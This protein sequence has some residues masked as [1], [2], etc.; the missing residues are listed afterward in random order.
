MGFGQKE[1]VWIFPP[2][3]HTP[4]LVPA[5]KIPAMRPLPDVVAGNGTRAKLNDAFLRPVPVFDV[6]SS[7]RK[8][9]AVSAD[10][11]FPV[12]AVHARGMT[13]SATAHYSDP[14]V[15]ALL[16]EL[17]SITGFAD[18]TPPAFDYAGEF[19]CSSIE[20]AVHF[21]LVAWLSSS[22]FTANKRKKWK[23]ALLGTTSLEKASS[24][25]WRVTSPDFKNDSRRKTFSWSAPTKKEQEKLDAGNADQF[26]KEFFDDEAAAFQA[27]QQFNYQIRPGLSP[28]RASLNLTTI[29]QD[30]IALHNERLDRKARKESLNVSAPSVIAED[31]LPSFQ[32]IIRDGRFGICLDS[33]GKKTRYVLGPPLEYTQLSQINECRYEHESYS[34]SNPHILAD[35]LDASRAKPI[36]AGTQPLEHETLTPRELVELPVGETEQ[37]A[38]F[39]PQEVNLD[40]PVTGRDDLAN[41]PWGFGMGCGDAKKDGASIYINHEVEILKRIDK[42]LV[43]KLGGV[44][45]W[46]GGIAYSVYE[47]LGPG[48]SSD[49]P[50]DHFLTKENLRYIQDKNEWELRLMNG[51]CLRFGGIDDGKHGYAE[52]RDV[53]DQILRVEAEAEARSAAFAA[54]VAQAAQAAQAEDGEEEEGEEA[55]EGEKDVDAE[56]SKRG[57]NLYARAWKKEVPWNGKPGY[58]NEPKHIPLQYATLPIPIRRE[59]PEGFFDS[60]GHCPPLRPHKLTYIQ[61]IPS[62]ERLLDNL[63][64]ILQSCGHNTSRVLRPAQTYCIEDKNGTVR[65]GECGEAIYLHA[66]HNT[67]LIHPA[68]PRKQATATETPSPFAYSLNDVIPRESDEHYVQEEGVIELVVE[69]DKTILTKQ[70]IEVY[71]SSDFYQTKRT[72][73]E[74]GAYERAESLK[75]DLNWSSDRITTRRSEPKYNRSKGKGK[76]IVNDDDD[77]LELVDERGKADSPAHV[78]GYE[79]EDLYGEESDDDLPA[80]SS[81]SYGSPASNSDSSAAQALSSPSTSTS[82]ATPAKRTSDS[83]VTSAA[84]RAKLDAWRFAP[85]H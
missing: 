63:D 42:E 29:V 58:E 53:A 55:V 46:Q 10:H 73:D 38:L 75:G 32:T 28:S 68:C 85:K 21:A 25:S 48:D 49:P 36:V 8:P 18:T 78:T 72:A 7:L 40:A 11:R 60:D 1:P 24:K 4:Y 61:A 76:A 2:T 9:I 15:E 43:P 31:A 77:D 19:K 6:K 67:H 14:S 37:A 27:V 23:Q 44:R 52:A 35:F 64:F 70:F 69:D 30:K 34:S 33:E 62:H 79:D 51:D 54:Q 83:T 22:D 65:M 81:T 5:G 17:T 80:P 26:D 57:K 56:H 20:E 47:H 50:A 41:T 12:V 59:L 45:V 66:T 3:R 13:G 74:I 71:G 84:T 16:D 39:R 82:S